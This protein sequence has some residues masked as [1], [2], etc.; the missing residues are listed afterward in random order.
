M[1]YFDEIEYEI[2][3][4]SG[5]NLSNLTVASRSIINEGSN[6]YLSTRSSLFIA[7]VPERVGEKSLN[8]WHLRNATSF[9]GCIRQVTINNK[10]AD[11]LQAAKVR[12]KV[13]PGCSAYDNNQNDMT[14]NPCTVRV[15]ETSSHSH[16]EL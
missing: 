14:S 16:T 10:L 4:A 3:L 13:S 11:F 8:R 2:E 5:I 6:E 9:N 12:H 15:F 1:P 7:G